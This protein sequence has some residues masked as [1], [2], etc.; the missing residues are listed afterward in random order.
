MGFGIVAID[1]PKSK[2][3]PPMADQRSAEKGPIPR[4]IDDASRLEFEGL[5]YP[6]GQ[7]L[8]RIPTITNA[9]K[10]LKLTGQPLPHVCVVPLPLAWQAT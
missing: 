9:Q 6:R 8:R 2:K 5:K 7:R 1:L 3:L 10:I 4:M